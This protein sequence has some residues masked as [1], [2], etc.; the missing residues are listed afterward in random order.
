MNQFLLPIGTI[1]SE[2]LSAGITHPFRSH[3]VLQNNPT[4]K[5]TIFHYNQATGCGNSDQ[6][7]FPL[8]SLKSGTDVQSGG[9]RRNIDN[10]TWVNPQGPIRIII[11]DINSTSISA[12]SELSDFTNWK[13]SRHD[14]GQIEDPICNN[15]YKN[16]G[17]E[18]F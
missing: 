4:I 1:E 10:C 15:I 5:P 14:A 2:E 3:R 16:A 11:P 17:H 8:G 9:S 18:I 13:R 6:Y 12:F 7:C